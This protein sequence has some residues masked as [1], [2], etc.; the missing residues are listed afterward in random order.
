VTVS[1]R[2][3]GPDHPDVGDRHDELGRVL[4]ELGDYHGARQQYEE[5]LRI[6]Q[7]NKEQGFEFGS[8]HSQLGTV[9]RALGDLTTAKGEHERAL[10][11]GQATSAPTTPMSPPFAATSKLLCSSSGG[12]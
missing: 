1:R 7:A 5:A 8:R 10:E 4:Q 6:T 12:E 9:L 2:A 3:L 11:I